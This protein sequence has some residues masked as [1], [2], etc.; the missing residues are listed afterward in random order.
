MASWSMYGVSC[1]T[2]EALDSSKQRLPLGRRGCG[3]RQRI[4]RRS[5]LTP[6]SQKPEHL[7]QRALIRRSAGRSGLRHRCRDI[8]GRRDLI[9]LRIAGG[10]RRRIAWRIRRLGCVRQGCCE[11]RE[12]WRW[13]RL[14]CDSRRL[15]HRGWG[16]RARRHSAGNGW[17]RRRPT[18]RRCR[19][20]HHNWRCDRRNHPGRRWSGK[21]RFEQRVVP[22]R[23]WAILDRRLRQRRVFRLAHLVIGEHPRVRL[24]ARMHREL[25]KTMVFQRCTAVGR[26]RAFNIGIFLGHANTPGRGTKPSCGAALLPGEPRQQY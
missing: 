2:C 4:R 16:R 12:E 13:R 11:Q 22:S 3:R 9:G 17:L 18:D 10:R 23:G 1:C 24:V 19:R 14:R 26:E 6:A 21:R 8:G 25:P 15:H 7:T 20:W 5:R